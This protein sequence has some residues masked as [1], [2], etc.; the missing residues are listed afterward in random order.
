MRRA[1]YLL[2]AVLAGAASAASA[3]VRP[4]LEA[5]LDTL[6]SNPHGL[7]LRVTGLLNDPEWRDQL[8][9]SFTIQLHWSVQLWKKGGIILGFGD[10]G[11]PKVEWDTEVHAIPQLLQFVGTTRVPGRPDRDE[12]F[13]SFDALKIWQETPLRLS[14]PRARLDAGEWYYLVS[15]EV[16]ALTQDEI[17]ARTRGSSGGVGQA[18]TKFLVGGSSMSLPHERITFTIPR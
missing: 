14:Q 6:A 2:A 13:G 8:D 16:R 7:L 11:Q 4:V 18:L 9:A 15:V 5:R 17:D 12:R 1:L 10:R 3:Q